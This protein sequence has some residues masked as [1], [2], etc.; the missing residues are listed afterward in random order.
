MHGLLGLLGWLR[1]LRQMAQAMLSGD[2][3]TAFAIQGDLYNVSYEDVSQ[4][5]VGAKR[6]FELAKQLGIIRL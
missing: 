3:A 6:L 1:M 2:Y 4:W 5:L